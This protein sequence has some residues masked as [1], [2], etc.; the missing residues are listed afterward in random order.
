[1]E[2]VVEY[3]ALHIFQCSQQACPALASLV[4]DGQGSITLGSGLFAPASVGLRCSLIRNDVLLLK[5][6][7]AGFPEKHR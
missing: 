1:M 7:G 2:Q 6:G 5:G 3:D 4:N